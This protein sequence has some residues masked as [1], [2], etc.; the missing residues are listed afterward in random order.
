MVTTSG[1]LLVALAATEIA[2]VIVGLV[3]LVKTPARALP[4]QIKWPYALLI[5]LLQFIGTPI[6]LIIRHDG[7]RNL[8]GGTATSNYTGAADPSHTGA[9]NPNHIDAANP[10]S[11]DP[12]ST[13]VDA[14][15]RALYGQE[16]DAS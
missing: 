16:P 3:F 14:T 5:V 6:F 10:S 9:A 4:G 15:I 7:M 11:T 1:V 12:S 8:A 13:G 2:I